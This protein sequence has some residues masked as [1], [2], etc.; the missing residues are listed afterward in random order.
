MSGRELLATWGGTTTAD[1]DDWNEIIE[2][3]TQEGWY[4]IFYGTV[5]S[6]TYQDGH[7]VTRLDEQGEIPGEPRSVGRL[8]RRLHRPRCAG[9]RSAA[10]GRPHP[11]L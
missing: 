4:K 5:A 8:C 10:A 11:D 1:R 2:E 3:G 6:M 9:R 7:V